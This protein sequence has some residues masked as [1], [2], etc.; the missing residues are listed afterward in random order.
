CAVRVPVIFGPHMFHFEEI[1]GLALE[2]GAAKQVQ[3]AA[4]LADAVR[5]W[6][7][8]ADLRRA[9]GEAAHSLMEDNH[10]ALQRTL[11]LMDEKLAALW[12]ERGQRPFPGA[13]KRLAEASGERSSVR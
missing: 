9:A 10:G 1:A 6:L 4:E 13:E 8:H 11:R 3:D 5:T 7:E 2:R 12:R